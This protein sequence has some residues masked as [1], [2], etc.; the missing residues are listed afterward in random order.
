MLNLVTQVQRARGFERAD[1]FELD[2][3]GWKV[4]EE[5]PTLNEVVLGGAT[6]GARCVRGEW[7]AR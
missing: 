5:P 7:T 4:I 2:V 1:Q 6:M 3:L